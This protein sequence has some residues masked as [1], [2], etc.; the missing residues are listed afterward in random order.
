MSLAILFH[1]LCA[2]HVSDFN[3]STIRSLR[4]FYHNDARSNKHKIVTLRLWFRAALIYINNCPTRT[5]QGSLFIILPVRCTYFGCQ[6]H[7]SSGVHKTVTTASGTVAKL[8]LGHVG[9]R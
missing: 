7:P 4:L 3:I 6:P 5:T 2:Q 8:G 1:F 9:G